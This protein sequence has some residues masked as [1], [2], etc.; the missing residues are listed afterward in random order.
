MKLEKNWHYCNG[1][2][3]EVYENHTGNIRY[4]PQHYSVSKNSKNIYSDQCQRWFFGKKPR[5]SEITGV[6]SCSACNSF[7][8][9]VRRTNARNEISSDKKQSRLV[10]QSS[11]P[12]KFLSPGSKILRIR[13]K[14]HKTYKI[15]RRVKTL[16]QLLSKTR[17]ALDDQQSEEMCTIAEKINNNYKKE[18]E[19]VWHEAGESKGAECRRLL[20][21]IWQHDTQDRKAFYSDQEKNISGSRGNT[22]S[23]ITYRIA[24]AVYCRSP[25][26]YDALRSYNVLQLPSASS[27][28]SYRSPRLHRP[29]IHNGIREYVCEQSENY[30]KYKEELQKRGQ[31]EPLHEGILIFD[32]VKITSKVKWSSSGQKF[33]GLA[34]TDEEFPLLHDVYEQ[35]D[36]QGVPLPAEYNLQF[37]WRDLTSDFDVIGPYFSSI[38]SY[39]H[40]FVIASVNETM[41]LMHSC[42]FL[43]V[44]LVC[45]GASTNLAAM[46]LMCLQRRGAF[47]CDEIQDDKHKVKAWFNNIFSPELKVFCCICP[48]HQLKNMINALFQ[49]RDT[50]GG[51][52]L[53]K[54]EEHLPYF[55]WKQIRDMYRR[56]EGR[57]DRGQLRMVPGLLQSHVERDAW[58]K[59]AV[60]PAKIMQVSQWHTHQKH[61][62]DLQSN[63]ACFGWDVNNPLLIMEMTGSRPPCLS[64]PQSVLI[65]IMS[66]FTRASTTTDLPSSVSDPLMLCVQ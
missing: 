23:T 46:K 26:A 25:A 39:D 53:F 29:G 32:E 19:K 63:I 21:E 49:S 50:P 14:K 48:S 41:R 55:G 40:R 58:T 2:P 37:L 60:F 61:D 66:V 15:K 1:I 52:K 17:V 64:W 45:D 59:L 24:L 56:E 44:G 38:A 3:S 7:F 33:F 8:R 13:R 47:G 18:L 9:S 62:S 28:K 36:P 65:I 4:T 27:L 34:L 5:S 10:S 20:E 42:Q 11:Y 6:K 54:I 22:W 31:L 35:V 16:G 12:L 51:T 43:V 57:M 30:L